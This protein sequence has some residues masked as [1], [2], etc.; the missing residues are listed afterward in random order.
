ML[1][2]NCYIFDFPEISH[3][4]AEKTLF[5]KCTLRKYWHFTHFLQKICHILL[6]S[7]KSSY[8]E[9]SSLYRLSIFDVFLR[10]EALK[11]PFSP[12]V[13]LF[14]HTTVVNYKCWSNSKRRMRTQSFNLPKK[15]PKQLL[16]WSH[17]ILSVDFFHYS[18][19]DILKFTRLRRT[20]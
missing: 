18:E 1:P 14:H 2:Q 16:C 4:F 10:Y 13:N 20:I 11:W 3:F 15:L 9:L 5:A 8:C 19:I 17:F 7:K 12:L 6:T